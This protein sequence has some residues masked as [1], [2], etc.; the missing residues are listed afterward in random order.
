[1]ELYLPPIKL[2]PK[3]RKQG[4]KINWTPA[5]LDE[6]VRRFPTDFNRDIAASLGIGWRSVV[7]KAR[8]L[9]LQ[10]IEGFHE[11]T[12][13]ER[14][15][16]AHAVRKHNPAQQG[17]GFVIPGS[18]PHRFQKGH[19]PPQADNPE[20]VAQIHRKRNELIARERIRIKYGLRRLS[21]LKLN[22]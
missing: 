7:R 1:M 12:G 11:A 20:L 17:K 6:L 21:K 19:K 16:R 9:G 10:K 4:I 2:E 8:E 14:G 18:E 5:M 3:P 13:K 22:A 15:R